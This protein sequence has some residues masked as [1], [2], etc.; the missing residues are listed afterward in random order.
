MREQINH[1]EKKSLFDSHQYLMFNLFFSFIK[2][3][4]TKKIEKKFKGKN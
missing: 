4:M 3:S 2:K 1:N